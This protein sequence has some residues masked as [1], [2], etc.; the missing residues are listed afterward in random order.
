MDIEF[1]KFILFSVELSYGIHRHVEP[2]T[3]G[4]L[5]FSH[6]FH[7]KPDVFDPLSSARHFL[8]DLCCT[9]GSACR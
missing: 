7:S 5:S 2:P 9:S 1:A 4:S 3:L 6:D 8:S